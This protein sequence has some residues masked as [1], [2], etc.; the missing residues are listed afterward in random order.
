MSIRIF[1]AITLVLFIL[2]SHQIKAQ[3]EGPFFN[4]G[5]NSQNENEWISR[6]QS[7]NENE[8]PAVS[9]NQGRNSLTE[10]EQISPQDVER[11]N[12]GSQSV[13]NILKNQIAKASRGKKYCSYC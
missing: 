13:D 2:G 3:N 9:S 10:N 11:Q 7:R 1:D 5:K 12:F 4:P 8:G 6:G